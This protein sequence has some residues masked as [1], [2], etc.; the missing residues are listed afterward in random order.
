MRRVHCYL[1]QFEALQPNSWLHVR[2]SC[3]VAVTVLIRNEVIC[4]LWFQVAVRQHSALV[5]YQKLLMSGNFIPNWIC[6][7]CSASISPKKLCLLWGYPSLHC[8][9]LPIM[10]PYWAVSSFPSSKNLTP[11]KGGPRRAFSLS[12][13][14]Y[15]L[16]LVK[17]RASADKE[18]CKRHD[19]LKKTVVQV[20]KTPESTRLEA[21]MHV[22]AQSNRCTPAKV[23]PKP[24]KQCCMA[25][26]CITLLHAII[27]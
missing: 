11:D 19:H 17:W 15:L 22:T 6:P 7:V 4:L 24:R 10:Q 13:G 8:W 3:R 21:S 12:Y 9:G 18:R 1:S 27:T 14:Q 25:P 2:K 16:L 23:T 26:P 5:Q 20:L